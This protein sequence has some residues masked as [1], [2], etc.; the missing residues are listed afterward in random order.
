MEVFLTEVACFASDVESL[1]LLAA[2]V[3]VAFFGLAADLVPVSLPLVGTEVVL[4]ASDFFA[5]P[6]CLL[7][8]CEGFG[9]GWRVSAALV[10]AD[11]LGAGAL[12]VSV[13]TV[14][15]DR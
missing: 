14:V 13:E 7:G 15:E 3:V 5:S 6:D 12:L 10:V 9:A 11:A 1:A 2:L 8:L 4:V